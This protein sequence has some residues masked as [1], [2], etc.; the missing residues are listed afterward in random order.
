MKIYKDLEQWTPERLEIRKW[1]VTGTKLKW[2]LGW[3]E[4]NLTEL[5]TLLAEEYIEEEEWLKAWEIIERWNELEPIAKARYQDLTW[6]HVEEVGFITNKDWLWLSPD[7]IISEWDK[8]IKAIHIWG[9]YSK[10]VEIK[11]PMWKTYIKYLLEDKIPKEYLPQVINYF[12]VID[13]LQELD[14]IIY[15]PWA[16]LKIKDIHIINVTRGEL[17]DKI[18]KANKKLESFRTKWDDLENKIKEHGNRSK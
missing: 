17:Q 11:C 8:I 14:F 12:V 13:D 7:G 16:S 10:W 9:W 1:K 3:P 4:A 15:H 18:D 6:E 2:V 5:Y